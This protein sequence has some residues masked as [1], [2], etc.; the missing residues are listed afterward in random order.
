MSSP[1]YRV[2]LLTTQSLMPG[3]E[4]NWIAKVLYCGIDRDDARVAFHESTPADFTRSYGD[5][6]RKT[7]CEVISDANT[8]DFHDDEVAAERW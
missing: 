7:V 5:S 2:S 4:T 6:A 1:I 3:R 8:D